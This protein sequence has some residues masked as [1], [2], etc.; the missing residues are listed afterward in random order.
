MQLL[1]V[2]RV[3]SGSVFVNSVYKGSLF[4]FAF[5]LTRDELF[6]NGPCEAFFE[7]FKVA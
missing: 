5:G 7:G 6:F 4:G 2:G 1:P 3:K